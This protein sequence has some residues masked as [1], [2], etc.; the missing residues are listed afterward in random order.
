MDIP[1]RSVT[2]EQ[3]DQLDQVLG[4]FPIISNLLIT[5]HPRIYRGASDQ[6]VTEGKSF[7]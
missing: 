6:D 7:F 2:P 5:L 1:V 4:L 3:L